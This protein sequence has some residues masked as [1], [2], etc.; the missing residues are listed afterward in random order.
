MKITII[1][2]TLNCKKEFIKTLASIKIIKNSDIQWIV[3]DGGSR[4]GTHELIKQ[5]LQFIDYYVSEPDSGIYNAWNKGLKQAKGD[6]IIFLGAGDTVIKEWISCV[7]KSDSKYDFIYGDIC[8]YN[9]K[10]NL[11]I[12]YQ[13]WT[14]SKVEMQYRMCVP[15]SGAAQN[16]RIFKDYKFN[17]EYKIISD[18]IFLREKVVEAKYEKNIIQVN[19]L[20]GGISE[21]LRGQIRIY[22]ELANY[23]KNINKTFPLKERIRRMIIILFLNKKYLYTPFFSILKKFNYIK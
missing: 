13:P 17:E 1:T 11:I 10:I 7:M 15:H 18:W 5:N 3:I 19:F 6:W 2:S 21:S 22:K 16:S 20:L 9:E 23:Y 14:Y 4:D 8:Q 12:K